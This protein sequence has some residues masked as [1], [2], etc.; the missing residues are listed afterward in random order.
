[1]EHRPTIVAER[2]RDMQAE[3]GL[4][5][6]DMAE[7]CG[8]PK[9]SLENYM[10]LKDPQRPGLDALIAMADGLKVSIDWLV[11]RSERATEP[12]FTT[13]DYA[14]F[15]HS[16]VL[17]LL[18]RILAA[19]EERPGTLEPSEWRI[20]GYDHTD[21]AAWA[22]LDFTKVVQVQSGHPNRPKGYFHRSFDSLSRRGLEA[23]DGKATDAPLHRKP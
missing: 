11:G 22:V 12:E 8:L 9:R 6:Q 21:L 18:G 14:V 7:R 15:C 19:E 1:M 16:V 13:E 20:M 2:L 10:N 5:I 17:R 4:T 3:L 23:L